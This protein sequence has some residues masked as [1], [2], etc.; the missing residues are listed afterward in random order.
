MP[1]AA[2]A[3]IALSDEARPR[4]VRRGRLDARRSRRTRRPVGRLSA[5]SKTSM[6][7]S[8]PAIFPVEVG[9]ALARL[10]VPEAAIR[11][12]VDF[13]RATAARPRDSWCEARRSSP[14]YR[15][16]GAPS[17]RRRVLCLAC[18]GARRD[19]LHPR[20]RNGSA[21]QLVLQRR[22][23]VT[24]PLSAPLRVAESAATAS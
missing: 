13:A 22:G 2:I 11:R 3:L 14:S 12:L 8:F 20:P 21:R 7:S 19:A 16:E 17:R 1:S 5:P 6:S 24:G 9:G 18:V 15:V 10:G 23:A 4:R